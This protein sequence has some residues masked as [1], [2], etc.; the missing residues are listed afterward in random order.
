MDSQI[1]IFDDVS[2]RK[3]IGVPILLS[4][5]VFWISVTE[6]LDKIICLCMCKGRMGDAK[7]FNSQSCRWITNK[8]DNVLPVMVK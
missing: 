4:I 6:L 3:A 1:A 2:L 7:V 5:K 8:F